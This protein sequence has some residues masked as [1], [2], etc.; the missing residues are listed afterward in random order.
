MQDKDTASRKEKKKVKLARPG[1]GITR[2][3][4][5]QVF[6]HQSTYSVNLTPLL[7]ILSS[8]WAGQ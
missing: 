8:Q 6:I 5:M 4:H 3:Q 7:N 1:V 2:F